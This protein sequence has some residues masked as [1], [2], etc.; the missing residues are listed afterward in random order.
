MVERRKL[1]SANTLST[2]NTHHTQ[3]AIN[4]LGIGGFYHL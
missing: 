4:G 2:G 1:N 3:Q